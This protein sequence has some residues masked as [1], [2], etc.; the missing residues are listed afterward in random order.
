MN[1]LFSID[2]SFVPLWECCMRSILKNGGED[3][4]ALYVLHSDLTEEDQARMRGALRPS[5]E[6]VFVQVPDSLFAGFPE[7]GRYPLQIYYRLASPLLLPR[8][9]DR[10]L[11]LDVDT[12]ILNPLRQLYSQPFDGAAFLACSHTKKVMDKINKVRLGM[13]QEVRYINSGVL[14][15]DLERMRELVSLQQ[16]RDYAEK[17]YYKLV[18]PDQDILTALLGAQSRVLDSR[19]YNLSDKEYLRWNAEHLKARIDLEWVRRNTVVVH[20]CGKPKPWS[21][22]YIGPLGILWQENAGPL[23]EP[24]P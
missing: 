16:I 8:Q 4:Y 3:A 20:Y 13:E 21:K 7:T 19:L 12:V 17:N 15:L 6:C 18:L 24:E 1:L 5:D 2:H 23:T 10:I 11:Y 9:M 14:L 22:N